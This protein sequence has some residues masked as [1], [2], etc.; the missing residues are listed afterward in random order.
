[1]VERFSAEESLPVSIEDLYQKRLEALKRSERGQNALDFLIVV[2]FFGFIISE[3]VMTTF[4]DNK[5]Q[6][7][8][9]SLLTERKFIVR[10]EHSANINFAHENLFHFKIGRAH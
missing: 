9:F 8:L 1:N 6:D 3:S 4:L 5:D 7:H 10:N 2:S